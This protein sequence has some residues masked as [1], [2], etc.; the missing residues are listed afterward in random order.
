MSTETE[1]PL[2]SKTKEICNLEGWSLILYLS[3][4][5]KYK[6]ENQRVGVRALAIAVGW[7]LWISKVRGELGCSVWMVFILLVVWQFDLDLKGL[8]SLGLEGGLY[9]EVYCGDGCWDMEE[10]VFVSYSGGG[11]GS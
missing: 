11:G 5:C 2:S 7:Y 4:E 3:G 8:E 6:E 9:D 1:A 10:D